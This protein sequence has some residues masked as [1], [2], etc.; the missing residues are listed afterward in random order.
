MFR[1]GLISLAFLW[2][3]A[4]SA[5]SYPYQCPG[6]DMD[7]RFV[8]QQE[9]LAVSAAGTIGIGSILSRQWGSPVGGRLAAAGILLA[10]GLFKEAVTDSVFSKGA[11]E[12]NAMGA[13]SGFVLGCS[14]NL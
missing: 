5:C 2:S 14:F 9:H 4:L 3:G 10:A 13:F 1:M 8:N 6:A 12:A 11:M 7:L